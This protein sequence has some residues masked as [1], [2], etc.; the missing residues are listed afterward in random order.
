[1]REEIGGVL[2]RDCS[3]W[4]RIY[5]VYLYRLWPFYFVE[6]FVKRTFSVFLAGLAF[7]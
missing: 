5:F 1:M 3:K 7:Y 4:P 2:V 6:D